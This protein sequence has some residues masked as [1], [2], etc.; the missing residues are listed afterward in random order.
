MSKEYNAFKRGSE[1]R[2]WDLHLHTPY[3]NLNAKGFS[4]SD[5]DFI[6]KIQDKQIAAVALTNYFFFKEEE[7]VLQE[8][9]AAQGITA[10]LNLEL[11]ASYTNK[12]EQCCDIHVIFSD[13]VCKAEIDIFLTKLHL[14]VDG[15]EKMAIHLKTDELVKATVDF[16]HLLSVLNDPTLCLKDRHFLGFLSR[17]HGDGRSSSNFE[18]LYENCDFLLHSSDGENNLKRDREFWLKNGRPLY[19]RYP[20]H[21]PTG[22]FSV[23]SSKEEVS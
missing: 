6:K 20:P 4:A 16:K 11:R 15:L 18:T 21:D 2:K 22:R 9:L 12:A 5:E 3:T 7:F 19:Q 23:R 8:K 14:N 1:W 17:G 10:F 13:D